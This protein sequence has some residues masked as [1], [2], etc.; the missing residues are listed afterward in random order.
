MYIYAYDYETF[1]SYCLVVCIHT[2]SVLT[3]LVPFPSYRD[4]NDTT[5]YHLV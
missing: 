5:T 2:I 3:V 4:L 1:E